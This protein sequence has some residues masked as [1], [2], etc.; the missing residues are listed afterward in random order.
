M[1]LASQITGLAT[2]V[3]AATKALRVSIGALAS[4]T[5]TDKTS[6]VAA[7]NEVKAAG[8]GGGSY[9]GPKITV[10]PTAPLSP[11]AGDLWIDTN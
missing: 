6:I 9:T 3:G 2:A 1:S 10:G 8:G 11:A 4:L 5:T 7:I